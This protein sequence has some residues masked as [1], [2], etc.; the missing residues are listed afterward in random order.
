[1]PDDE[2]RFA[3]DMYNK[4]IVIDQIDGSGSRSVVNHQSTVANQ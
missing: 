4:N 1:M 2:C 3:E